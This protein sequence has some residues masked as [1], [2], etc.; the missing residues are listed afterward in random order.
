MH[1]SRTSALLLPAL[2]AGCGLIEDR[3]SFRIIAPFDA[4]T[5]R[6]VTDASRDV[7]DADVSDVFDVS[8]A[9][10]VSD[11]SDVVDLD[12]DVSDASNDLGDASNDLGD[13][14]DVTDASD[15]SDVARTCRGESDC[16]SG[17][18]CCE[19]TGVCFDPACSACCMARVDGGETRDASDAGDAGDATVMVDVGASCPTVFPEHRAPW[20]GSVLSSGLVPLRLVASATTP[21]SGLRI[22]VCSNDPSAG[23]CR[24]VSPLIVTSGAITATVSLTPGNYRWH[25]ESQDTRCDTSSADWFFRVPTSPSSGSTVGTMSGL[26]FDLDRDGRSEIAVGAPLANPVSS[27]PPQGAVFLSSFDEMGNIRPAAG[28]DPVELTYSVT[29]SSPRQLGSSLS[30]AGDTNGD[31]Y[32][33]LAVGARARSIDDGLLHGVVRV[34][35]GGPTALDVARSM[36]VFNTPDIIAEI[37]GLGDVDL[38]GAS[39]LL[40]STRTDSGSTFGV[41]LLRSLTAGSSGM[42]VAPERVPIPVPGAATNFGQSI[43][44]AGDVDADLHA[45]FVIGAPSTPVD[46]GMPHGRAF[47]YFGHDAPSVVGSPRE[48]FVV[49]DNDSMNPSSFGTAVSNAGNFIG[50]GRS[51][52]AVGSPAAPGAVTSA[53]VHVFCFSVERSALMPISLTLTLPLGTSIPNL[54][55]LLVDVGDLNNDGFGDLLVGS[56][57][58]PGFVVVF[59][60]ALSMTP[61]ANFVVDPLLGGSL[62]GVSFAGI[63]DVLGT[64]NTDDLIVSRYDNTSLLPAAS[65]RLYAGSRSFGTG[66]LPSTPDRTIAL[67]AASRSMSGYGRAIATGR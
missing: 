53:H 1:P 10:D 36:E 34:F 62:L 66:L 52:V 60:R 19:S 28:T 21:T 49:G 57:S 2:L 27:E 26:L 25:V 40:V 37:R 44:A 50:S 56:R 45:D 4:T 63:G 15:A 43:S 54:G 23:S 33:E 48:L 9:S 14:R 22:R 17:Q 6:D 29:T 38:N 46:G 65:L 41:S 42:P 35:Y 24:F 64:D 11:V 13:V 7:R 67:I 16:P 5:S 12:A 39:D 61:P 18:A 59:G 20:S 30:A 8:D 55:N 3:D 47:L 32:P 51:C 31:G 58:D